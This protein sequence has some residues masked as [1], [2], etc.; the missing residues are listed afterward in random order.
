MVLSTRGRTQ[1][2]APTLLYQLT[3]SIHPLAGLSDS[4]AAASGHPADDPQLLLHYPQP[5]DH[6]AAVSSAPGQHHPAVH[7]VA[8]AI[9]ALIQFQAATAAQ[10][11]LLGSWGGGPRALT[12]ISLDSSAVCQGLPKGV[13]PCS[14]SQ[15]YASCAG[16]GTHMACTLCSLHPAPKARPGA[17]KERKERA[18]EGLCCPVFSPPV[19]PSV[20]PGPTVMRPSTGGRWPSSGSRRRRQSG[21]NR[22][23]G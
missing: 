3:L 15:G 11:S 21:G 4:G 16:R 1:C 10:V 14:L 7:A 8:A 2:L 20:C 19:C 18:P 17:G 23:S 12:C 6:N 13:A 22:S 5:A 9:A